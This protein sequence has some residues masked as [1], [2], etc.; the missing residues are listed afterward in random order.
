MQGTITASAATITVAE[1]STILRISRVSAY[2]LISSGAIRAI[3]V[4]KLWRIPSA[5]LIRFQGGRS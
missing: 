2:R 3:R 4:G 5:E 1:L